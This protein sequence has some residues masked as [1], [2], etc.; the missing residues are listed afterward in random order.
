MSKR[1]S[2]LIIDDNE[3]DRY[4]LKR[5]LDKTSLEVTT[6]EEADGLSALNF[7]RDY[8]NNRALYP[9]DFPPLIFFLDINMPLLNGWEFLAEFS[10]LR[11][12]H[13]IESS[14]VV[15]F[16]TSERAEDREKAR[17]YDFVADYLIK[18]EYSSQDLERVLLELAG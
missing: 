14:V 11:L 16:T 4:L 18:G 5:Q 8:R 2:L 6:F 10:Q 15:M 1:Y 9:E 17:E 13:A 3:V 12:E 7:L